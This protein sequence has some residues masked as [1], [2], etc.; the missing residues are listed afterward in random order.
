MTARGSGPQVGLVADGLPAGVAEPAGPELSGWTRVAAWLGTVALIYTL[1]C[2]VSIMSRGFRSLSG[3]AAQALFAFADQPLVALAVGVLVTVL[4]QSSTTKTAITVAAV[5][6]GALT[7]RHSIPLILGANIG[8]TVTSTIVAL[9]F[10]K[11]PEK[12]RRAFAGAGISDWFNVLAVA[13]FLPLEIWLHPLERASRGLAN[14]L[15]GSGSSDLSSFDPVRTIT[16]P[17]VTGVSSATG[18]LNETLGPLVMIIF[19][20]L[21]I[22]VVVRYLGDLLKLLMIGRA[23]EWLQAAVGRN[24]AIAMAAGTGVTIVTQSST[25]TNTVLIPFV[26]VGALTPRQLYP[27]TL[28]AGLGTT[29]TSVLAAFAV[30]GGSASAKIGL[31]A[32]FIHVLFNVFAILVIFVIPVLRP[33]PLRCAEAVA[34]VA[35]R[36]KWFALFY[37]CGLFLLLPASIIA[38]YAVL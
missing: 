15:Y 19:G 21:L 30:T 3:D 20:V 22:F 11:E 4:I 14:L 36:R 17:V 37:I 10:A 5:G 33:I 31:Q 2:A 6:T 27:L 24:D 25:V 13:I 23:S 32:S 38:L 28:G 12:F 35:T 7:L 34:N 18:R 29:L 26:G 16:T 1:V 9:G 8:T